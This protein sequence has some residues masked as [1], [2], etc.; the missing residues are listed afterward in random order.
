MGQPRRRW[1]HASQSRAPQHPRLPGLQRRTALRFRRSDP[2]LRPLPAAL[3]GGG[4]H[5][6]HAGRGGRE[7]LIPPP[8][9]YS[10]GLRRCARAALAAAA[11]ALAAVGV[12]TPV[13]AA[14]SRV[15]LLSASASTPSVSF[16][17]DVP[18]L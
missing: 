9:P 13:A 17:V 6:G 14:P 8:R 18:P 5:P 15:T 1:F 3:Q 10:I 12:A 16:D 11:W 2:D 4:R 7:V